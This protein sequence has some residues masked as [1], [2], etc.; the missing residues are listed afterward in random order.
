MGSAGRS[1]AG[2]GRDGKVLV[3]VNPAAGGGRAGR[4]WGALRALAERMFPFEE[5][6]TTAAGEG[7]RV[8]AEAAR[9]GVQRLLA[10][11][12]D[13]T[14]HEVANGAAGT[15]LAVAVLPLG[16]GND[17][18]RSAGFF[19]SPESLLAGLAGGGRRAVDLGE[20][21]GSLYINV[22]GVGFDAEVARMVNALRSKAGG[23]LPYVMTAIRLAFA[24]EPPRLTLR[25]DGGPDQP[26]A[27]LLVAIGNASAYGGGM[28]ICPGALIDD[29]A[30][31]ALVVGPLRAWATLGLLPK[32][33]RGRHIDDARVSLQRVLR[34]DIDGPAE[35][36]VHADGEIVGGLPA[37]FLVRPRALTLWVPA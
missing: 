3:L 20:V 30:L 21:H 23:A 11:G 33:F 28:R 9:A 8:A 2:P 18:A 5:H 13:G 24:Y 36:A 37:T 4:R 16:T 25:F 22:A 29:G 19:R 27:R 7:T 35:T 6:W 15:D 31:D 14:L 1:A 26:G 32:V 12:G 10:V 34:V 17:F